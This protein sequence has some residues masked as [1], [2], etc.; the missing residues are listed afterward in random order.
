MSSFGISEDGSSSLVPPVADGMSPFGSSEDGSSSS[1]PPASEASVGG[2]VPQRRSRWGRGAVPLLVEVGA[3]SGSLLRPL[4]ASLHHSVDPWTVEMSPPARAS[5]AQIVSGER[6]AGALDDLPATFFGVVIANEL[7]DNLPVALAARL[8]DGWEE[9]WVGVEGDQLVL[10]RRD[11]RPEVVGW[12]NRFGLP[13]PEGG[14]VEVQLAAAAWLRSMLD[15]LDRGS[16]VLVDYGDTSEGLVHRRAEGTVRTYRKHHLGPDPLLEPG[17]TDIT[18]DVNFT[19]LMA[20]ARETGA[21][22]ALYRQDDF[23]ASLG[24]RDRIAALREQER[25]LARSGDTMGQLKARSDRTNAEALLHPR[26]LGDFRVLVI[27]R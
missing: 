6:V 26:G 5:L 1:V 21:R 18:V 25:V 15:R 24:L 13:C 10:V 16:I 14:I 8:G 12:A 23:L 9:R 3:G 11:A 22:A 2:K 4:L 19:A 27:S 20:T 17:A 7:I